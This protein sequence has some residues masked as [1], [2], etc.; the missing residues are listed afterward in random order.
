MSNMTDDSSKMGSYRG[1]KTC[2]MCVDI[3]NGIDIIGGLLLM[4]FVLLGLNF[5][6]ANVS[7]RIA[8]SFK[9][10]YAILQ[11]PSVM[12]IIPF[13]R[14]WNGDTLEKRQGLPK[15]CCLVVVS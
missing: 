3:Q 1:R 12:A 13:V 6:D 15:A 4:N 9:Y 7:T 8:S 14:Y 5:Y 10:V 11:I 2:C